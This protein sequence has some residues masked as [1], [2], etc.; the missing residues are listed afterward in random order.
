MASG[1][2]PDVWGALT[3]RT[4][5]GKVARSFTA[6]RG[7]PR[8]SR[9]RLI[10]LA[11]ARANYL[12]RGVSILEMLMPDNFDLTPEQLDEFNQ[13]GMLRLAGFFPK[14][15]IDAMANRLWTDLN[16]RYRMSPDRPE[17]WTVPLPAHFQ[18]LRRS[19]A[20][21]E[22]GSPSMQRLAD[23][24]LG[25][26]E[27]EAPAFWGKPLVTFPTLSPP[28]KNPGWHLDIG[29][30]ERLDPQSI[31]R[32]FT[33]LEPVLP[34][35]GGTLYIAGSHRLAIDLE[36]Q[37]GGPLKS[38]QVV[39]MLRDEHPWFAD[40]FR[41]PLSDVR[42]RIGVGA[43]VGSYGVSLE[44]MTGQAGDL[45]IMHL[46]TMHG[47]AHNALHRPRLMLTEWIYRDED[48]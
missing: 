36:R 39:E 46:G 3:D 45:V 7:G 40:L 29:G 32:V 38:Q 19:G 18:Q 30:S 24:M 6:P 26:G 4:L 14:A 44:E 47:V 8:V 41:T 27:W 5:S 23:G 25:A 37:R 20:F 33:F 42:Q 34:S 12:P 35:G 15:D 31:L 28:L 2:N 22:F 16:E 9:G 11:A 43:R 10:A 48:T 17:T 13:R 21:R 1:H